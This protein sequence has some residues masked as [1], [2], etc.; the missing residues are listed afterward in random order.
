M[1]Q[2]AVPPH[3][4]LAYD[5][6]KT[7]PSSPGKVCR[8]TVVAESA[9]LLTW[10]LPADNVLLPRAPARAVGRGL[11][12]ARPALASAIRGWQLYLLLQWRHP[13]Q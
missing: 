5:L 13:P 10:T 1:L 2:R 6:T 12:R 11:D 3:Y 8:H 9:D 7:C 4:M